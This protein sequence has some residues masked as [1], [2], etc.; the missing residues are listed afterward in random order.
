M[1][2]NSQGKYRVMVST[3]FRH[4]HPHVHS[5]WINRDYNGLFIH[6]CCINIR[7]NGTGKDAL[8]AVR[9]NTDM[10]V[11]LLDWLGGF[12]TTLIFWIFIYNTWE[13]VL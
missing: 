2:R 8:E 10:D 13:C 9:A 5:G 4:G 12:S 6:V 1:R 3:S 7:I 11:Y